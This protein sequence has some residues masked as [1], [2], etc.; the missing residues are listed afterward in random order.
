MR[1]MKKQIKL[2]HGRRTIPVRFVSEE[3]IHEHGSGIL[4]PGEFL[5]GLYKARRPEI[6]INT[7][8]E[9]QFSTLL[10]ELGEYIIN[11]Y[12]VEC[13]H[14]QLSIITK[15]LADIMLENKIIFKKMLGGSV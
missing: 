6:F 2:K 11:E 9:G 3:E 7:N 1:H 15:V 5:F 14:E 12:G 8:T 10:H 4:R 13:P